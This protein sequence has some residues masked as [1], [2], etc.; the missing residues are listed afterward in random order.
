MTT[1]VKQRPRRQDRSAARR[2]AFH[3][4]RIQRAASAEARLQAAAAYLTSAAANGAYPARAA[5]QAAGEVATHA[6]QVMARAAMSDQA[7]ALH[8]SKLTAGGT[9][10]R[11][12]AAALMVLRSAIGRLPETDRDPMREHYATELAAEATRIQTRR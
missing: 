9:E 8:E 2:A 10:V 11:R 7:R 4:E 6:R 12:L 5:R 1:Q 3:A